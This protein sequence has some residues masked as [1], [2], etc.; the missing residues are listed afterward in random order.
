[1]RR[2]IVFTALVIMGA[3][4]TIAMAESGVNPYDLNGVPIQGSA[5]SGIW[6]VN[7]NTKGSASYTMSGKTGIYFMCTTGAALTTPVIVKVGRNG[8]LTSYYHASSGTL[9]FGAKTG[10]TSV[11]FG[12]Y[13]A[14]TNNVCSGYYW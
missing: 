11:T 10:T 8:S 13:S 3:F 6:S 12:S 1:M 5:F 14:A 2:Y 7:P 9:N 4:A